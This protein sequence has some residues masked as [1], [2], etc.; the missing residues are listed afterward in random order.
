MLMSVCL[1]HSIA[2]YLLF[3]MC[4]SGE[5]GWSMNEGGEGRGV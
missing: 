1:P 5:W 4:L 2:V 3:L